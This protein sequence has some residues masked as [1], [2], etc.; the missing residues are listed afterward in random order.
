MDESQATTSPARLRRVSAGLH[1]TEIDVPKDSSVHVRV[2]VTKNAGENSTQAHVDKT[3]AFYVNHFTS[4][5]LAIVSRP[6]VGSK[7][8]RAFAE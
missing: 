3:V 2:T 7:H 4:S 6:F 5:R 1:G 8:F